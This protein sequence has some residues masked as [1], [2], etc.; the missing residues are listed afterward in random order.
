[1]I[2]RVDIC[3][4]QDK[5]GVDCGRRDNCAR[6]LGDK[7]DAIDQKEWEGGKQMG[8]VTF[9]IRSAPYGNCKHYQLKAKTSEFQRQVAANDLLRAMNAE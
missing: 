4:G 8:Q 3:T 7:A 9:Y 5:S 1:M 2:K 6:W